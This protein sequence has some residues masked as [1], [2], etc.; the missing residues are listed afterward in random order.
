MFCHNITIRTFYKYQ[1][2]SESQPKLRSENCLFRALVCATLDGKQ[3]Y[4]DMVMAKCS[5]QFITD[6]PSVTRVNQCK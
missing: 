3:G 1:D 2:K 5:V 4:E 6:S